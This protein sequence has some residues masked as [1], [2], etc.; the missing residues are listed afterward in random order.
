M[1]RLALSALSILLGCSG[2]PD[3]APSDAAADVTVSG[4]ASVET[5]VDPLDAERRDAPPYR[6]CEGGRDDGI[7]DAGGCAWEK[8]V[9]FAKDDAGT[10]VVGQTCDEFRIVLD[11][12][13]AE[14]AATGCALGA[15]DCQL[16]GVRVRCTV[17]THVTLTEE[18]VRR[19]CALSLS[20]EVR[21]V[22]CFVAL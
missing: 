22:R 19:A 15:T 1:R 10:L 14:A 2:D 7:D 16:D 21:E 18:D 9:G 5:S 11:P 6:V 12:P 20:P 17:S 13:F 8:L 3:G 4:D